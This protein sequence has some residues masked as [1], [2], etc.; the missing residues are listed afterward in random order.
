M[1]LQNRTPIFPA[2]SIRL[3]PREARA[4]VNEG[5]VKKF[6]SGISFAQRVLSCLSECDAISFN[7][8]KEIEGHYGDYIGK[9]FG[10]PVILA[11]PIIPDPPPA[12]TL[13][14]RLAK[15]LNRF[16][17]KEV[18]FCSFGS[19]CVLGKDQFEE[20]LLGLELTGMPFLAAL[21]Q[22]LG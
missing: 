22:P 9:Q 7:A 11:G 16:K 10:K 14:E 15:W 3:S 20:L 2:S 8:C 13:D 21:K 19:E 17:A 6:G 1:I 5:V 18:I 4:I 12:S